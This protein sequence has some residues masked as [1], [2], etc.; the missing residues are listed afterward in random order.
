MTRPVKLLLLT[1]FAAYLLCAGGRYV[2]VRFLWSCCGVT[3]W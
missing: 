2:L 1:A 3:L